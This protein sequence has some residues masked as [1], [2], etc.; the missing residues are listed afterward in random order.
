[1]SP[2]AWKNGSSPP[3]ESGF[4]LVVVIVIL[5]LAGFLASQMALAVRTELRLATN[6]KERAAGRLLAEAGIEFGLFRL[7]DKP[8]TLAMDETE[9]RLVLARPYT[10]PLTT[11]EVTYR[12]IN[13]TGKIDLNRVPQRLLELFLEFHGLAPEQIDTVVD[14][15][16]DWRDPDNLHRLNGA[17]QDYYE[18]LEDPYIPRNGRIAEPAEFFLIKGTEPLIDRF[19]AEDV[20]TV[21]SATNR[22][23]FFSLTPAMLEFVMEGDASRIEAYEA[24]LLDDERPLDQAR[25]QELMGEERFGLLRPYLTF[26]AGSCKYYTITATA[27]MGE[28]QEG[29]ETDRRPA[30]TVSVLVSHS[31]GRPPYL[32]W[33]QSA[34]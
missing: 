9:F 29:A 25:A 3:P 5:L 33:R 12:V 6:V 16:Y 13:E 22:I 34:S 21:H 19:A 8:L 28:R 10:E 24:A 2:P 27:R 23:N 26:S 11:G 7:L 20:F 15:L 4:A 14:S 31:G 32:A 18:G 30:T 17:E 1:M